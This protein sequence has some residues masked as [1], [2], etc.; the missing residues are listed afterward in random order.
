MFYRYCAVGSIAWAALVVT[1]AAAEW[2]AANPAA[3]AAAND[4]SIAAVLAEVDRMDQSLID[5][6][7]ARF[8]ELLAGDLVVNNPQNSVSMPGDTARLN[9]GGR[10]SYVSYRRTVEYAGLRNGM[11]VLMGEEIV[12]PKPPNPMAGQTV[13]RRFTDLWRQ[14]DGHWRLALR[15]ATIIPSR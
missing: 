10:I 2:T 15:Q 3:A 4:P 9:A 13:H 11:V 8:S 6:D 7:H 5:D 14:D 1:P 12:V